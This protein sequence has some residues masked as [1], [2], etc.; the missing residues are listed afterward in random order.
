MWARRN[1]PAIFLL[2]LLLCLLLWGCSQTPDPDPAGGNLDPAGDLAGGNPD[3]AD[4]PAGGN[5]D[6]A[7]D[8]AGGDPDPAGGALAV[9]P[10]CVLFI[11]VGKA[12]AA[13]LQLGEQNYLID[14]G[15]KDSWP[16]LAAAL[17]A[18]GVRRL[19]GVFLTHTHDDHVGGLKQLAA[20]YPID[21]LY[22]AG[23]SL[24]NKKGAHKLVN[25]ADKLGLPYTLLAAGDTLDAGGAQIFVLGPLEL[26]TRD[27]NDNS[28][29]LRLVVNGAALLF[30]GDMQF[31][32]EE[33]LLKSGVDVACDLLKVG[34]HGNPDA[35][36]AQFAAAA[37]PKIAVISTD[38][39]EDTDSASPRVIA[40]LEGAEIYLTQALSLGVLAGIDEGGQ[41][42]VTQE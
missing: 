36:S 35:T 13:L 7:G 38:T 17:Q 33:T 42:S 10:A 23:I 1:A 5:L 30:T 40:A 24:P 22:F 16:R 15:T 18:R 28:L 14:T 32:E 20:E 34:N 3:P 26:N 12:D 25:R 2:C 19:D 29:V 27:D 4:D 8:L 37:V 41:I 39:N 21:M 6:P 9:S 11:N 31:S